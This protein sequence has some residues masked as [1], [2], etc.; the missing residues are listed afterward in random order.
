MRTPIGALIFLSVMLLLDTYMFQAVKTVSQSASPKTRTIIYTVY[1]AVTVISVA[2]F[3]L[4]AFTGPDTMP[5]K[6]RTYLF[7]TIIGLFLSKLVGAVFFLLD[8]IRRVIYW[9]A[10]RL[11]MQNTSSENMHQEGMSRAVFMSWLGITAGSGLFGS[12]L[13][14][15]SNKY[16]YQVKNI[17]LSFDNLPKGF[18]GIR[19]LQI[20]DIHSGSFMD[21]SKV[22]KGV[23]KILD[24]GADLI[25]FTGD[26]VNNLAEEM[27]EYMDVFSRLKA[28]MGVYS[29]FGNHDYAD[30]VHWNNQADKDANLEKLKKVHEN[31]GWR[32]LLDENVLLD[33]GGDQVS[34][35]GVQNISAKTRFHSY[36][37]M[38]KAYRGTD[39]GHF[40]ILLSHD[41]SHWEKEVT[42]QF[43]D[44]D[45][46]FSGHTHGMQ[47]GVEIP[48]LKWSP[49]QYIYKQWKGLY[50]SGKQKLYVNTGFGFIGYPGRLGI[51]PE[52]TVIELIQG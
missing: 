19:I 17:Q 8:D 34:L 15:F 20:S 21:K 11:F 43:N 32:L 12:L 49:V 1:W 7:A 42:T 22:E 29:I 9:A 28:P 38:Q 3:L 50:E 2:G 45:L 51:L 30:Y 18:S 37:N 40:K 5:K 48:G 10:T 14:G 47:F 44:V 46:T 35:I 26:L 27:N 24:Q 33:R 41:P 52:I 36:G 16:N 23:Q 25:L 31:L 6:F 39:P 13:Y 4:F